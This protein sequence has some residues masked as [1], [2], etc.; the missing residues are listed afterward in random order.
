M[1]KQFILFIALCSASFLTAQT[2]P[3][4]WSFEAKA[5]GNSEYELVFTADIQDGWATYSQF[6][7]SDEG[8]VPTR[9]EFKPSSS[10]TLVD[11]AEE[12]GDIIKAYDKLFEMNL[13]KIKHKGTFTQKVK[14]SDTSKPIVGYV[15]FMVCNDEMCLPPKDV[16]FSFSLK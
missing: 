9:I 16:D 6:L 4:S 2:N 7:E 1:L 14:V 8:P 11:K 13:I 12:A 10:Y 3:V 15:T 5:L